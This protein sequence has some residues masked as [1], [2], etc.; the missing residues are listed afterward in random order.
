MRQNPLLLAA[1][2]FDSVDEAQS[3]AIACATAKLALASMGQV[4]AQTGLRITLSGDLG[5]G[6]TTWVRAFLQACGVTGRIKSPSFSVAEA[7]EHAGQRF[8]HLDFYRQS[9]PA[10][11]QGGGL[12]DLLTE[13]GIV[14]IEWPEH[15]QGL[16]PAHIEILIGWKEEADAAAPRTIEV[17]FFELGDAIRIADHLADWDQAAGKAGACV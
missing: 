11:W 9:N 3:A 8:H 13:P 7:Y 4:A 10:A 5:A 16:P 17:R 6:K 14:L 1:R 2:R 12:R 15:A